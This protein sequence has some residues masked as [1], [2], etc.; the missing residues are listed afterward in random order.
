M[1]IDQ[2]AENLFTQYS[3]GEIEGFLSQQDYTEYQPDPVGFCE[4]VLGMYLTDDVKRMMESVRDN[5]IT[6]AISGNAVGK[7]HGASAVAHWFK[8]CFPGSQV[9]TAAAPPEDNLKKKLWGEIRAV[10]RNHPLLYVG[11]NMQTL[12]LVE[13]TDELSFLIG[14]TIP[15]S[16]TEDERESKFSGHHAPYILFII[17]EGDAVP[18][19]V[20]RAIDGC[21]S[22]GWARLLIMFNPKQRRGTAYQMTRGEAGSARASVVRLD[23]LHHPNVVTGEDII[24]G[25]VTRDKV[26]ERINE[27]T[28][29]LRPDEDPDDTCF[30]IP[31]FLIDCIGVNGAGKEYPPLPAG[32]RRID[33]PQFYYKVLGQYPAAGSNQLIAEEWVESAFARWSV[34]QMAH[35]DLKLPGVRPTLG[36]DV[37][38]EGGD[39]NC[40]AH[41]YGSWV[42]KF[43][44][45]RGMDT[46]LSATHA[47]VIHGEVHA[48]RTNVESDGLGAGVAPKMS[49]CYYWRCELCYETFTEKDLIYCPNCSTEG[50]KIEMKRWHVDARK[51]AMSSA[52]TQTTEM[53]E[54]S[55]MRDQLFWSL[56]EWLRTDPGA[57]L[58]PDEQLREQ[59]ITPTF[60]ERGGKVKI[61]D[62]TLIKAILGYSPDKMSSLL[63]TFYEIKRPRVRMIDHN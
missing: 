13:K 38:D 48:L 54:F 56:R 43:D 42:T 31:K 10:V 61:M 22:G 14:R 3:L 9:I 29:P 19:E 50:K 36:M 35:P 53:G 46:D 37:A 41:R 44:L 51:V 16:G 45:W 25:A 24:P 4:R 33:V 6:V 18:D 55:R 2:L 11:Y 27:W 49:R 63:L 39:E 40:V 47:A 60:G 12:G 57:A 8:K 7:T 34:Y 15:Q 59:L 30:K 23:A 20:Y 17:D 5:K 21:M 26:L 1:D 58:S 52:P 32:Y 62:G 28:K